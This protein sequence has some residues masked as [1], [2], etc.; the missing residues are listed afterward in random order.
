MIGGD[1]L[2]ASFW[3]YTYVD[4][5]Y[6]SIKEESSSKKQREYFLEVFERFKNH[7]IEYD[8]DANLTFREY[9]DMYER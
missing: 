9:F 4:L 7:I 2:T 5:L 1:N 3:D 8:S 6:N